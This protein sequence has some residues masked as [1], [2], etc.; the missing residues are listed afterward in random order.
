MTHIS[1][2]DTEEEGEGDTGENSRVN[3]FIR[4]NTIGVHN[5]LE[6]P[7][8][9]VASEQTRRFHVMFGDDVECWNFHIHIFVF[10]FL[11]LRVDL[12]FVSSGDP[13]IPME[14]LIFFLEL[15]KTGVENLFLIQE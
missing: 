9:I 10:N 1:E 13:A 14:E 2:H 12:D 5:F 11:H 4:G 6:S 7:C 8:E 15:I 3:F